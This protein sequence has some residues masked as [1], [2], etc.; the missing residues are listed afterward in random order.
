MAASP[1]MGNITSGFSVSPRAGIVFEIAVWGLSCTISKALGPRVTVRV[2]GGGRGIR[3]P[4]T[5]SGTVVFKTT[6]FNRSRIPPHCSFNEL[7]TLQHNLL[8]TALRNYTI[9][10]FGR[11]PHVASDSNSTSLVALSVA[12]FVIPMWCPA[13]V[14][15]VLCRNIPAVPVGSFLARTSSGASGPPYH[16]DKMLAWR[17]RIRE[18]H[19][20]A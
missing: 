18:Y 5:V 9:L 20:P 19:G 3:T 17:R 8:R 7:K 13:V 15:N 2:A 14:S 11:C 12:A 10:V 16:V 6:R 4:G 1:S